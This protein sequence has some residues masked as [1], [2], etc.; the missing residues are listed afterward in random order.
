MSSEVPLDN[1]QFINDVPQ[2]G[3]TENR[4]DMTDSQEVSPEPFPSIQDHVSVSDSHD[5]TATQFTTLDLLSD[6][7]QNQQ[8]DTL[9]N[10][11]SQDSVPPDGTIDSGLILF[12]ALSTSTPGR[13]HYVT[14]L[15]GIDLS[16]DD[17]EACLDPAAK[18]T[19]GK[20]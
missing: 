12:F 14:I 20:N 13:I 1:R 18:P 16:K 19:I 9:Q 2:P 11:P 17:K 5:E 3:D 4:R 6:Q 10:A 15:E 8:S 7:T